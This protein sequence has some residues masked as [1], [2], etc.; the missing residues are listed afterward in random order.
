M[1]RIRPQDKNQNMQYFKEK[2][3]ITV[4]K[5]AVLEFLNLMNTEILVIKHFDANKNNIELMG[6]SED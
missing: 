4:I 2:N 6:E 5:Q 3:V 1:V